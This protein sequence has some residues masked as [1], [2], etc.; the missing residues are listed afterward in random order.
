MLYLQLA[1]GKQLYLQ[2]AE[3]KHFKCF[4]VYLELCSRLYMEIYRIKTGVLQHPGDGGI[5][6]IPI[7][8]RD[9]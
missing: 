1:E 5:S 9:V 2:L 6:V 4:V 7:V 3:G 8:L